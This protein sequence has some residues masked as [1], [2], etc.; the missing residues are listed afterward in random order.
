M[1]KSFKSE[2][3]RERIISIFFLFGKMRSKDNRRKSSQISIIVIYIKHKSEADKMN[4]QINLIAWTC[5]VN[6]K[7]T[8]NSVQV[9][10]FLL[11]IFYRKKWLKGYSSKCLV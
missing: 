8:H 9:Y 11:A 5:P 7:N 10:T 6:I 4:K 1:T 2:N 3:N